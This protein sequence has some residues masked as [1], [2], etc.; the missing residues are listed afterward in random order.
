VTLAPAF[1]K[2][3]LTAHVTVSVGWV[4]AV[5]SFLALAAAGVVSSDAALVRSSYVAMDFTY[6]TIVIPLGLASLITGVISSLGTD[7]G[8]IRHYWVVVKLLLT[9]PAVWMMLVHIQPVRYAA[10]L[11]SATT[12]AGT[13]LDGL[14]SQLILYAGLALAILLTATVLSTYKPRGRTRYGSRNK[15][16]RVTSVDDP[17]S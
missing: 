12:F 14:R 4:G 2:F 15:P 9:V 13:D 5:A 10:Q 7:W 1:R 3:A 8:L 17:L 16:K 6:C 11:A